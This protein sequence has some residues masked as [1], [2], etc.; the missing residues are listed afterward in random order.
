MA[1]TIKVSKRSDKQLRKLNRQVADRITK[2]IKDISLLDDP[3][4]KG[5]ALT[6]TLRGLWRYRVEDYRIIC[7]IID[8]ELV[9][10]VLETEHRSK[11]YKNQN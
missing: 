11:V 9:I 8:D 2:Y 6:G 5:K 7:D 4:T 1:W 3:R 10:L